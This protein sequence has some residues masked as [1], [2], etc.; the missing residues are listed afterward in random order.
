MWCGAVQGKP[1]EVLLTAQKRT[2]AEG[3]ITGVFC[4]LHTASPELQQV[5]AP[6]GAITGVFCFLHTASPELPAGQC[7]PGVP[8]L[9]SSASCTRPAPSYS[10]SVRPWGASGVPPACPVPPRA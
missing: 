9:A 5:S 1:V 6:S 4:F 8:S 2:D 3:A 7:A 10:R